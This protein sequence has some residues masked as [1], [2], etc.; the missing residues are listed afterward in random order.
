M[1]QYVEITEVDEYR[2]IQ[3]HTNKYVLDY[4]TP[5]ADT[6]SE[7]RILMLSVTT[8]YSIY[9]LNKR[10]ENL[11]QLISTKCRKFIDAKGEIVTWKPS[12][13]YTVECLLIT[14]RWRTHIGSWGIEVK[15][16]HTKFIVSQGNYKY[17][18][19]VKMGNRHLLF[20]L[21]NDRVPN[22]RKKI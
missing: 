2:V 1:R 16:L 22:T 4:I 6:Y 19:V 8:P 21:V 12:K 3:T 9:P 10:I 17:A 11:S 13:F 7:R 15:G 20:N 5:W 18:Q 14:S